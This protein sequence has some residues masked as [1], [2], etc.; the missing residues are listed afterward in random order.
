MEF[1]DFFDFFEQLVVFFSATNNVVN[2]FGLLGVAL[3]SLRF[4]GFRNKK[5]FYY[6]FE[7]NI[8]FAFFLMNKVTISLRHNSNYSIRMFYEYLIVKLGNDKLTIKSF[9][10]YFKEFLQ[11]HIK[12]NLKTIHVK[13]TFDMLEVFE[14]RYIQ[15]Y[16]AF[17]NNP[18]NRNTYDIPTNE[19]LGFILT[20]KIETGF[21]VP[22]ITIPGLND[23]YNEDWSSIVKRYQ[24]SINDS[25][26]TSE[27]YM[28]Y[29][30]L[31]WGPSYMPEYRTNDFKILQYGFGDESKTFNVVLNNSRNSIDMW[32]EIKQYSQ[33]NGTGTIVG[34]ELRIYDKKDYFKLNEDKFSSELTPFVNKIIDSPTSRVISEHV[35]L[36]ISN[37]AN[38]DSKYFSAYIWALFVK[39]ENGISKDAFGIS[40]CVAFFEHANLADEKNFEFLLDTLIYKI[41]VHFESIYKETTETYYLN[42]CFNENIYERVSNSIQSRIENNDAF[43]EW[44]KNHIIMRRQ[45]TMA[46][47]LDRFDE[48][49]TFDPSKVT[50]HEVKHNDRKS[51]ELLSKFYVGIYIGNFTD[52]NERETLDNLLHYLESEQLG[53]VEKNHYHILIATIG[54]EV[55]GGIVANYFDDINSGVIEFL[56]V[57]EKFRRKNIGNNL[58]EG[59]TNILNRDSF[60]HNHQ[61]IDYIFIEV[62]HPMLVDSSISTK[63][64]KTISFW[65]KQRFMALDFKYI[66]PSIG[67]GK[68]PVRHLLLAVKLGKQGLDENTIPSIVL[69]KFLFNY[70]QFSMSIEKPNNDLAIQENLENIKDSKIQLQ[71]MEE[72]VYKTK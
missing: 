53:K 37:S 69:S 62:D 60:K 33:K 28:F 35:S 8:F 27:L 66:Q 23:H 61:G 70:A 57:D 10:N 3:F 4:F 42:H 68:E 39:S 22:A 17:Y 65:Q 43:G 72:F 44:L 16:F 38:D 13:S 12:S 30:W 67:N 55:V 24:S 49:F 20:I 34:M 1:N 6:I 36:T 54:D 5:P 63:A 9:Q 46:A 52:N 31:M 64:K 50:I 58:I 59:M 51:I 19:T 40:N 32:N 11:L 45:I 25:S 56:V 29:T 15:N 2:F 18:K 47:L 21:L 48:Q 14:S 71:N 26:N 7:K 41:I